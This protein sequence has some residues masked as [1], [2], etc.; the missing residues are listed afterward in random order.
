MG[1][2]VLLEHAEIFMTSNLFFCKTNKNVFSMVP[3]Y[4]RNNVHIQALKNF[5]LYFLINKNIRNNVA[6]ISNKYQ[7]PFKHYRSPD[8]SQVTNKMQMM[9]M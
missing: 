3:T 7:F 9:K 5:I 1:F 2:R 8:L 6:R 4:T